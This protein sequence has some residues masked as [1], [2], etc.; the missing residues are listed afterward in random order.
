MLARDS[1]QLLEAVGASASA[2]EVWRNLCKEAALPAELRL[3]WLPNA[4]KTALAAKDSAQAEAW[5]KELDALLPPP[6]P[7]KK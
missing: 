1:A 5:Q 4:K 3:A 6:P 7:E 2:V